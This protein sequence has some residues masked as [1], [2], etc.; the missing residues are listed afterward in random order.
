M[1]M[2]LTSYFHVIRRSSLF[3]LSISYCHINTLLSSCSLHSIWFFCNCSK[4]I[5]G[6]H[7]V[8]NWSFGGRCFPSMVLLLQNDRC[9]VFSGNI[10]SVPS[11]FG[12]FP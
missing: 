2:L 1:S 9:I 7:C 6:V 3:I 5:A 4:A 12:G 11:S 10:L 8:S